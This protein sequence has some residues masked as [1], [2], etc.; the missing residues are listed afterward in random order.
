M[1]PDISAGRTISLGQSAPNSAAAHPPALPFRNAKM[2][3]GQHDRRVPVTIQELTGPA[4]R[5]PS[6]IALS[7]EGPIP[8]QALFARSAIDAQ[9]SI[10]ASNGSAASSRRPS[11]TILP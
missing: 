10:T 3:E 6:E 1:L 7:K 9:A 8:L 11:S 4:N 5:T 2:P